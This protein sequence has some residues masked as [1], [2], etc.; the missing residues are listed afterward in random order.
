MNGQSLGALAV[1]R[2]ETPSDRERTL[3]GVSASLQT[4]GAL[5]VK[6]AAG[7]AVA[8]LLPTGQSAE[9]GLAALKASGVS[10]T[11]NTGYWA[12]LKASDAAAARALVADGTVQYAEYLSPL[13]THGLPTP[14]D[15]LMVNQNKYLPMTNQYGAWSQVDQGCKNIVVAVIDTGWTGSTAHAEA[16]LVP[17]S[18]WFDAF[19]H[20]KGVAA[21]SGEVDPHGTAVASIIA[22]T[23][24]G[25]G[26]GVSTSYNLVKVLPINVASG[27]RN[28]DFPSVAV[29]MDYAMGSVTVDGVTYTN[30]Y[31]ARVLN[32]SFGGDSATE[33]FTG[34]FRRA[35]DRGVVVVASVGNTL[36]T[37]KTTDTSSAQFSIGAG[38]VMFDGSH[39]KDPYTAGQGSSSGPG[40]DAAAPS[41][42][43]PSIVNGQEQYWSGTSFAAPWMSSQIA[44]WMYANEQYRA[45]GSP[46][47]GLKGQALYDHLIGCFKVAGSQKG[48]RNDDVGYGR[49]DTGLMVAA[50]TTACR[51]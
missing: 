16:N 39:W 18:A 48:A 29:A 22:M 1:A 46:T 31:P 6:P 49:L 30:P 7:A 28:L 17:K 9:A 25:G 51:R 20:Q 5:S 4:M 15:T 24:N 12:T 35:A 32:M 11:S 42:A 23:T 43:V 19:G 26:V 40:V 44:L 21:P 27:A 36:T 37:N 33:Y 47:N 10:V 3:R 41:M 45:D 13:K 38:G 50:N 2:T 34:L 8:V 14:S